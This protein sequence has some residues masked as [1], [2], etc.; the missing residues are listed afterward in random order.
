[1][2]SF[3]SNFQV[4]ELLNTLLNYLSEILG[5]QLIGVY[6][7]GSLALNDFKPDRSDIDLV[8]VTKN[9]LP[10][11]ILEKLKE[12]HQKI[13]SSNSS[14]AKRIECIYIPIESLK[15]YKE[16]NAYFPCLHIG[17]DFYTD[18]FGLLEKHVLREKGIVIQG[19]EPKSFIKPV[20]ANE[21][22]RAALNSLKEWWL[23]KLKDHSKLKADDYQVYAILTM[24]RALY[25]IQRGEITSKTAASQ[26]AKQIFDHK[27]I[28]LI[29]EALSWEI[30]KKF[31]RLSETLSY[32]RY[33]LIKLNII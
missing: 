24:C 4:N 21:L 8:V 14:Y 28:E 17:G 10:D 5:N 9:I 22:K 15:N 13:T 29:D 23:P 25:T 7:H 16:E 33:V 19:P 32:I 3:V 11:D 6:L 1:M 18:G 31:N 30:G 20:S 27:W 26:Y 2:K 12:I